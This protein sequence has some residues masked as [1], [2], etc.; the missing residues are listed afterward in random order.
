MINIKDH[1]IIYLAVIYTLSTFLIF[2]E[3]G[4]FF[5]RFQ[6]LY[7]GIILGIIIMFSIF[8]ATYI[9]TISI[10]EKYNWLED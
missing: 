8:Y 9:L 2:Y 6:P 3:L 10:P 4:Y 1:V 5:Y 7:L